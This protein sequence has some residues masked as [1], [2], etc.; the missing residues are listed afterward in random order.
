MTPDQLLND[1]LAEAD[2]LTEDVLR[3]CSARLWTLALQLDHDGRKA[4]MR[5]CL[6]LATAADT[7]GGERNGTQKEA[8]P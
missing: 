8:R 6:E 4:V 7:L 1:A 5:A 3:G 2:T